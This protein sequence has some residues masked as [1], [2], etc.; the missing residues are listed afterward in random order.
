MTVKRLQPTTTDH[1]RQAGQ[2]PE[3]KITFFYQ[4]I[5]DSIKNNNKL[6]MKEKLEA[7]TIYQNIIQ[8]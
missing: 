5:A 8:K 1:Q 2:K 3:I 6:I 4:Y 7:K